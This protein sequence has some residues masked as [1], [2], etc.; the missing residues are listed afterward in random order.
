MASIRNISAGSERAQEQLHQRS[1]VGLPVDVMPHAV[2]ASDRVALAC[3]KVVHRKTREGVTTVDGVHDAL[4][5]GS[6]RPL[7]HGVTKSAQHLY[8]TS[9]TL[10]ITQPTQH[11]R[12]VPLDAQPTVHALRAPPPPPPP[13]PPSDRVQNAIHNGDCVALAATIATYQRHN[14]PLETRHGVP[15]LIYAM[16]NGAPLDVVQTL[17]AAGCPT[18]VVNQR[19][20]TP[21]LLAC[22]AGRQDYVEVLRPHLTQSDFDYEAPDGCT[23][24]IATVKANHAELCRML[25]A[26]GASASRH[27]ATENSAL[28]MA[29]RLRRKGMEKMLLDAGAAVFRFPATYQTTGAYRR[30][31]KAA[32]VAMGALRPL[33]RTTTAHFA[34]DVIESRIFYSDDR[35]RALFTGLAHE[36]YANT[37]LRP[38][39][40][41]LAIVGKG[42]HAA[43]LAGAAAGKPKQLKIFLT[44]RV[45]MLVPFSRSSVGVYT[46]M[47]SIFVETTGRRSYVAMRATVVHEGAHLV[48]Q[49]LF[50]NDAYPYR[51]EDSVTRSRCN[52]V[53]NATRERVAKMKTLP[54]P[55]DEMGVVD[56]LASVF[57][58]YS[59]HR[60]PAELI[61]QYPQTICVMGAGRGTVWL[62]ANVPELFTFYAEHIQPAIDH[63]VATHGVNVITQP[64]DADSASDTAQKNVAAQLAAKERLY[65]QK[66]AENA[67]A[68]E[69]LRACLAKYDEAAACLPQPEIDHPHAKE[70]HANHARAQR[71]VATARQRLQVLV[72]ERWPNGLAHL[73]G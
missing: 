9:G 62:S 73:N 25:L 1:G 49:H 55:D 24:L 28:E 20:Q 42:K 72:G 61:V 10:V 38:L 6:S 3:A 46:G 29:H 40:N 26:A 64:S 43:G 23:P 41:F 7:G 34:P 5:H 47:N 15:A 54:W 48:M 71:D 56:A 65:Q 44:P 51:K 4:T 70:L 57:A 58:M 45:A 32:L 21:L 60:Y 59:P 63:Y 2:S 12:W 33:H 69:D 22:L 39:L 37:E 68:Q 8:R 31:A 67:R 52:A 66:M 11:V 16:E 50:G 35:D 13:L 53:V 18:K 17:L 30:D 36:L 19:G 27:T 14:T